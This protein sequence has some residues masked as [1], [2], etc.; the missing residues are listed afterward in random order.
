MTATRLVNDR[1][2]LEEGIWDGQGGGVSP[3]NRPQ[4][5]G[6]LLKRLRLSPWLAE[7]SVRTHVVRWRGVKKVLIVLRRPHCKPTDVWEERAAGSAPH[8]DETF[9][10]PAINHWRLN[11]GPTSEE[12]RKV[13]KSNCFTSFCFS[14]AVSV[15]PQL[16]PRLV[17][18]GHIATFCDYSA[19]MTLLFNISF[20]TIV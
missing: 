15:T 14:E 16:V 18:F 8:K 9:L 2:A 12:I 10:L 17:V 11:L 13:R 5:H 20:I 4:R 6:G 3:S 1:S 19:W 7:Y